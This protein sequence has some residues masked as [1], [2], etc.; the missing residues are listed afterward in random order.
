MTLREAIQIVAG[1]VRMEWGLL[2]A[3]VAFVAGA[4]IAA[5]IIEAL[6]HGCAV[7]G[8]AHGLERPGFNSRGYAG[9]VE[10]HDV[11]VD[12]K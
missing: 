5:V 6:N 7:W 2:A 12:R 11:C 9:R 10:W 8:R 3:V 1:L 4:L